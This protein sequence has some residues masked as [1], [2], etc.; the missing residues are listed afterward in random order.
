MSDSDS[1]IAAAASGPTTETLP[2]G[3]PLVVTLA[4]AAPWSEWALAGAQGQT[5][6]SDIDALSTVPVYPQEETASPLF[7]S[8]ID[9]LVGI[10]AIEIA[11]LEGMH[12]DAPDWPP[13]HSTLAID[14]GAPLDHVEWQFVGLMP[15][16]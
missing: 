8:D 9:P 10:P 5:P 1:V 7:D 2:A 11:A 3:K 15:L 13:D 6:A 14:Y 4:A 16:Q 12:H